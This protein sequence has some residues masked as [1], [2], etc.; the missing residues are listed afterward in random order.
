MDLS[1]LLY[2]LIAVG[3]SAISGIAFNRFNGKP[4]I[5][6]RQDD[7]AFEQKMAELEK[8]AERAGMKRTDSQGH[9]TPNG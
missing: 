1:Y 4:T 2:F 9:D 5:A 6:S 8:R 7:Q 3:I